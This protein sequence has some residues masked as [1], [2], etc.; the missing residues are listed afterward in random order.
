VSAE[1]SPQGKPLQIRAAQPSAFV[2]VLYPVVAVI[3]AIGLWAA[4]VH[5]FKV[6]V[7]ILPPPETVFE[8]LV[9]KI[10]LLLRHSAATVYATL[11]GLVLSIVIGVPFA[12]MLVWSKTL[13]LAML[14]KDSHRPLAYR[15]VRMGHPPK[16]FDQLHHRLLSNR[17]PNGLG[18]EVRGE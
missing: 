2:R 7:Y 13:E 3:L 6:P 10:H 12:M 16:G 17:D 9:Q 11:G 18:T 15:V 14:P 1:A 4:F 8:T 5:L